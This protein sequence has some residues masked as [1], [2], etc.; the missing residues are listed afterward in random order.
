LSFER[1]LS[2]ADGDVLARNV[3]AE[4]SDIA[5]LFHTGGTTGAAK[6]ARITHWGLLTAGFGVA[7]LLGLSEQDRFLNGLP[8]FHLGG[9]VT[10]GLSFLGSGGTN[11][12]PTYEGLRNP[13]VIDNYWRL[14]EEHE[15]TV[16]GGIP[17]TLGAILNASAAGVNL[18]RVRACMSGGRP[19]PKGLRRRSGKRRGSPSTNSMR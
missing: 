11:I 19:F 4:R 18:A 8:L 16:V 1:L 10:L 5:A 7:Q 17:T 13:D 15:V 2:R 6:F 14:V 3:P 9:T 12:I